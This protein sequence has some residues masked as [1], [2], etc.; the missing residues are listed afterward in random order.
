MIKKKIIG[1]TQRVDKIDSFNEYRDALDQRLINWIVSL[2]FVAVPIPNN[3]VD[4]TLSENL[5]TNIKDWLNEIGISGIVLSGGND[6]GDFKKRDL[7]E[8]SLL[9]WAEKNKKP[10]LGICRG[11]QMIGLYAGEELIEVDGHVNTRHELKIKKKY[12]N[13]FPNTVNSFHNFALKKC[14]NEYE[15]LAE[16]NNGCI[17]AIKHKKLLWEGWMWHPEREVLFNN[18]DGE[19]FKKLLNNEQ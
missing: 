19:R 5:Q 17:E 15:V 12:K 4:L 13:F 18:I 14:P 9:F 7:T 16:S 6:I 10:V 1:I 3:L 8:K 2:G 11:M